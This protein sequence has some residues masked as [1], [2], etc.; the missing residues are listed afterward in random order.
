[1]VIYNWDMQKIE[2]SHR[3]IIFT[4]IFLLSLKFLWVI[5]DLIFSLFIA[6]IIMS[7]LKPFVVFFTKRRIPR[8]LAALVIYLLFIGIIVNLLTFIFPPLIKESTNLFKTLPRVLQTLS[9]NTTH[10]FDLESLSRYVPNI[11]N[12]FFNL[13]SGLFSNAVFTTTTLFF[14][15]YFLLEEDLIKKIISPFTD[16]KEAL[17]VVGFFNKAE[18]RMSAWF[19]GELTL[20]VIVGLLSFVGFSLIGLKYVL[21]LAVLAGLLEIIPNLGPT[22]SA[23]PA[24]LIGLSGSYFLGFAALGVSVIVQQFENNLVV[25]VVMKRVVGLNPIITL[26]ALIIGGKFGGVLGVLISIPA[27]LFFETL[28]IEVV[29]TKEDQKAK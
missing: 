1:M 29:K 15:L 24:I 28:F 22:L 26:I 9:P 5:K 21:P 4:V 3:T 20:M 7:A 13:V 10:I 18:K 17:R 11:T 14:G 25:P 8:T 6:F 19:W 23:I 12:Q 27:T 16:E 2:V